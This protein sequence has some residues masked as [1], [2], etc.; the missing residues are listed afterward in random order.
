M[1]LKNKTI[2]ELLVLCQWDEGANQGRD[3]GLH[4][5]S[6][7]II[8]SHPYTILLS[9]GQ[10]A[11]LCWRTLRFPF[12][13]AHLSVYWPQCS[14]FRRRYKWN[15]KKILA[16][17]N[18]YIKKEIGLEHQRTVDPPPCTKEHPRFLRDSFGVH[19][20]DFTELTSNI[21]Y[22]SKFFKSLE[23]KKK[24]VTKN[25]QSSLKL[26]KTP[27][28]IDSWNELRDVLVCLIRKWDTVEHRLYGHQGDMR[29][30]PYFRGVRN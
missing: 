12:R 22:F 11:A 20:L 14:A 26:D 25:T 7:F 1:R 13:N 19:L 23:K 24:I 5:E 30:C 3:E 15:W 17:W 9:L 6:V 2:I 29:K 10:T 27:Q 16:G 21:S 4:R 28:N 18:G 8:Y